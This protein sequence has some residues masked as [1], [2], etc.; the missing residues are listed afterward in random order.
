LGKLGRALI[1]AV[2]VAAVTFFSGGTMT[3]A[4]TMAAMTF[5]SIYFLPSPQAN[6]ANMKPASLSD[7][8]VT[9]CREGSP[10]PLVYGQVKIPST[11]IWYG[12][13]VVQ[14]MTQEVSGGKGGG[15]SEEVTTGYRY[16]VDVFHAI[17]I[18]KVRV[19]KVYANDRLLRNS[20]LS[21][22]QTSGT[23]DS[24]WVKYN[25]GTNN[26][27]YVSKSDTGISSWEETCFP[28]IAW[29]FLKKYFVGENN[30]YIKTLTFL[31][32]RVLDTPISN[33][34]VVGS[35]YYG[36]NPA[37]IIYD[38][39]VNQVGYSSDYINLSS[40]QSAASYFASKKWGLN[41]VISSNTEVW[42]EIAK[43]L[44]YV[45]SYIYL[46]DDGKFCI[47]VIKDEYTL[48]GEIIDDF[49]EFS[50]TKKFID[51]VPNLFKANI[52]E[53]GVIKTVSVENPAMLKYSGVVNLQTVDLTFFNDK[54]VAM[55]RLQHLIDKQ[56]YPMASLNITVPI[57]YSIYNIG[58]V[59]RIVNSDCGVDGEFRI[60]SIEEDDLD[61]LD[62]KIS[63]VQETAGLVLSQSTPI[64][65]LGDNT[66]ISY[67]LEE[68][69][70]IKV[71]ELVDKE[72]SFILLVPKKTGYEAGYRIYYSLDGNN[73]K[74]YG[75]GYT[76]CNLYKLKQ[77]VNISDFDID[78]NNKLILE[79]ISESNVLS[80]YNRQEFFGS[81]KFIN[82]NNEILKYQL[83]SYIDNDNLELYNLIRQYNYSK[84]QSH[85][86][87]D[88]VYIYSLGTNI[89]QI[90]EKSNK[91][92]F[93]ICPFNNWQE[94]KLED[95]S[96][97]VYDVN[98]YYIKP[99]EIERIV[100]N[101]TSGGD[102]DVEVFPKTKQSSKGVGIGN[103]DLMTDSDDRSFMKAQL[104]VDTSVSGGE[105][106][107]YHYTDT[108][109]FPTTFKF[110][111]IENGYESIEIS[112]VVDSGGKYVWNNG[113]LIK[114]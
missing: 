42:Q 62:V 55:E 6:Q 1:G 57:K 46:D 45:N 48:A 111:L 9:Q 78:E 74:Y 87:D 25:D 114:E 30:T 38:L 53:D 4:A 108:I 112:I 56:S 75:I 105:Y 97:V 58:D 94:L 88:L 113:N 12:N 89:I 44:N 29:L 16:Y 22:G 54:E 59:I 49:K 81:N 51:D 77:Q 72:N 2:F 60:V 101:A 7:F 40:F 47:K 99:L 80:S 37:A 8:S 27:L 24:S 85:N 41:I 28:D 102:V 73:Y 26:N 84:Q 98:N 92:Y 19:L 3:A 106:K 10:I 93:K 100:I 66:T 107:D 71:L 20:E 76:F 68:L 104:F 36:N 96:A 23:L 69:T 18:G 91:I 33:D 31:L 65:D 79:K 35:K 43:I 82:I 34:I 17:C 21:V 11:I 95:V 109:S 61:S 90:P 83:V 32:R 13:L 110:K 15:G 5:F 63:L 103:A 70:N 39:L 50:M 14:E 86:V 52:V 67:E 64:V